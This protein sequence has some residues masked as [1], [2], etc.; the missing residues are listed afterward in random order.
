MVTLRQSNQGHLC[1]GLPT[2]EV[3]LFHH[4]KTEKVSAD[5]SSSPVDFN[6][7]YDQ[8]GC[9]IDLGTSYVV[10]GGKPLKQRVTQYSLTGE[11]TE[12]PDLITGRQYHACS[13]FV[14]SEGVTV[15]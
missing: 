5:G 8:D 10:T 14:N 15:S 7:A 4:S 12:L 1:W 2:G 13:K 9:G 3:L 11:V 6:V